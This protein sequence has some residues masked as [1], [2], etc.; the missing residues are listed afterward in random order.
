MA[1]KPFAFSSKSNET[2]IELLTITLLYTSFFVTKK[3]VS[4]KGAPSLVLSLIPGSVGN[5]E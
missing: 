3:K 2:L 5:V 1:N 4:K